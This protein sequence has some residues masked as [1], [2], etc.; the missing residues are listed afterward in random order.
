M[1]ALRARTTRDRRRHLLVGGVAAGVR[2][3]GRR[4]ARADGR[5]DADRRVLQLSDP[6]VGGE[7]AMDESWLISR[8]ALLGGISAASLA[9]LL[10]R[11]RAAAQSKP[12]TRII[13]VH[14]PEGMWNGAPRPKAG[15]TDLGVIF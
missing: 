10:P 15:G 13:L 14:V 8:R 2:G 12:P 7:G 11:G 6:G 9:T 1:A 4:F 3:L 5:A